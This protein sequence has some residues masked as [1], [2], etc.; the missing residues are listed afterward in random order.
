MEIFDSGLHADDILR[1]VSL[2]RNQIGRTQIH[3]ADRCREKDMYRLVVSHLQPMRRYH[4]VE[5]QL[6]CKAVIEVSVLVLL[7]IDILLQGQSVRMSAVRFFGYG[8]DR[9]RNMHGGTVVPAV[10]K[11]LCVRRTHDAQYKGEH[12]NYS[13]HFTLDLVVNNIVCKSVLILV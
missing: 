8:G 1:P 9:I 13:F 4:T 11:F 7:R 5:H 10:L 12:K 2:S 6:A 3:I